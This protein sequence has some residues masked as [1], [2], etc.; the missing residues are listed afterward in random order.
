VEYRNNKTYFKLSRKATMKKEVKI[1][2][3]KLS[4][5]VK[6]EQSINE[7]DL[8][9]WIKAILH[10]NLEHRL[11]PFSLKLFGQ[12]AEDIVTLIKNCKLNKD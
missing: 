5:N 1:Y 2:P 10:K 6:P 3:W 11:D 7:S 8:T 12:T 9:N 4:D